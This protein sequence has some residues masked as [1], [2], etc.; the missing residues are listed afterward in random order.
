M[1]L[2]ICLKSIN[3]NHDLTVFPCNYIPD[4]WRCFVFAIRLHVPDRRHKQRAQYS[5]NRSIA[6]SMRSRYSEEEKSKLKI[7]TFQT[8]QTIRKKSYDN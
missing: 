1:R 7:L 8:F 5:M 2:M 6:S 4:C 3:L